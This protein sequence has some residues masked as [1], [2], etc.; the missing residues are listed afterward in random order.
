MRFLMV[1]VFA[2]SLLTACSSGTDDPNQSQNT[3][4][5]ALASSSRF[6][7]EIAQL[8]EPADADN[9]VNPLQNPGVE[10]VDPLTTGNMPESQSLQASELNAPLSDPSTTGR[11]EI[12][13][14]EPAELSPSASLESQVLPQPAVDLSIPAEPRIGFRAPDFSLQTLDGQPFQLSQLLG[15]PVVINYW[16]TWCIPCKQELPILEKLHREY[17]Q[18]GIVFISINAIDQDSVDKVQVMVNELGMSFPVLLDQNR[19]FADVYQA[20]FF[21]T[22]F[23]V[24]SN[25]VIRHVSLGDNT[26]EEL[27]TSLDNLLAGLL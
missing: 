24:D 9:P 12:P 6:S 20:I 2:I 8:A 3:T 19:V 22:T 21:P 27:R 13:P 25:G 7:G 23:I 11:L 4:K 17:Q 15:K 10:Q 16:T 14:A 26:E 5:G 18:K 1:S